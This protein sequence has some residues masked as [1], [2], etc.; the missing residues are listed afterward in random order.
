MDVKTLNNEVGDWYHSFLQNIFTKINSSDNITE[1]D[2]VIVMDLNYLKQIDNITSQVESDTI[3]NYLI[4]RVLQRIGYLS[5][6]KFRMNEF[7]FKQVQ[8][9]IEKVVDMDKRCL[10][11]ISETVPDLMGRAYIDHFFT[12]EEKDSANVMITAILEA[13][14]LIVQEKDWMDD[15]TRQNSL[16]K[17]DKILVNTAYPEWIKNDTKLEALYDFVSSLPFVCVF[18]TYRIFLSGNK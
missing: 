9:G 8:M 16:I 2:H 5:T 7:E 13:F 1:K 17:A 14:R 12:R 10:D 18:L 6:P 4:W 11:A 3:Q 15:E